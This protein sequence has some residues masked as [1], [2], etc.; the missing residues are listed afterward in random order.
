MILLQQKRILLLDEILERN[1]VFCEN[2]IKKYN[3]QFDYDFIIE[4]YNKIDIFTNLNDNSFELKI[5][6]N[7]H[8]Y[9]NFD[10]ELPENIVI[11]DSFDEQNI[12]DVLTFYKYIEEI[13]LIGQLYSLESFDIDSFKK[14]FGY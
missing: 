8:K 10:D 6:F 7:L 5:Y 12:D 11:S 3:V 4:N 13:F 2:F 1:R 14:S 9:S